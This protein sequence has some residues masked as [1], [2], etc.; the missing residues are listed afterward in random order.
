MNR[1]WNSGTFLV[2][3]H[4]K[5]SIIADFEEHNPDAVFG[6]RS[7]KNKGWETGQTKL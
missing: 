5:I 2:S 7:H 4:L 6:N 3:F 1:E